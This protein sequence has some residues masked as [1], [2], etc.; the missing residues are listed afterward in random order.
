MPSVGAIAQHCK[1]PPIPMNFGEQCNDA[2]VDCVKQQLLLLL[3]NTFDWVC[4]KN[5][6]GTSSVYPFPLVVG[7]SCKDS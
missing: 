3:S 2:V 7:L 5:V 1:V 4:V 6:N